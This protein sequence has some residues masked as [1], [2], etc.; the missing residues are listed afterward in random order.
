MTS[1]PSVNYTVTIP[2]FVGVTLQANPASPQPVNT[3]ITVTAIPS[4]GAPGQIQYLFRVGYL[5]ATGW[6][7]TYITTDY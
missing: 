4:G 5:D 1:M 2:P 7:W 6:V 3:S